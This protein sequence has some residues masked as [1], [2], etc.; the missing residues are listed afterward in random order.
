VP[1]N[2]VAAGK[3]LKHAAHSGSPVAQSRLAFMYATGRGLPAYAVEAA[4]WHMI[5]KAGGTNDQ[6]L[7]DFVRK[8][9]P[10]DRTAAENAAKPWIAAIATRRP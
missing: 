9:K 7:E 2:E 1:K 4:K 3:Y 10:E 8:M 6:F 5:A